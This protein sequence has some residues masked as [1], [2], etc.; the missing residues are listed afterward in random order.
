MHVFLL[1]NFCAKLYILPS[2]KAAAFKRPASRVPCTESPAYQVLPSVLFFFLGF[3][4]RQEI[5]TVVYSQTMDLSFLPSASEQRTGARFTVRSANSPSYTP[6]HGRGGRNLLSPHEARDEVRH[7]THGATN[8]ANKEEHALLG[9]HE[10]RSSVRG[11]CET[12]EDSDRFSKLYQN[13][14]AEFDRSENPAFEGAGRREGRKYSSQSRS[15]SLDRRD[16]LRATDSSTRVDTTVMS[17][18]EEKLPRELEKEQT[19]VENVRRAYKGHSFPSRKRSQSEHSI[20]IENSFW[21][22]GQSIMERIEKLYGSAGYDKAKEESRIKGVPTTTDLAQQKLYKWADGG[23]FPR[24][25]SSGVG[26]GLGSEKTPQKDKYFDSSVTAVGYRR[27]SGGQWQEQMQGRY[28]EEGGGSWM[29]GSGTRSLDRARSRN[30]L[31]AQ[32]RSA[33]AAAEVKEEPESKGPKEESQSKGP[34]EESQSKGPKEESQSKGPKE[35]PTVFKDLFHLRERNTSG[36]KDQSR[37]NHKEERNEP[38]SSNTD[39]DVFE[40][41]S[42]KVAERNKFSKALSP[43]SSTSVRNKI[44]QFEALSQ[45]VQGSVPRRAFSVPAQCSTRALGGLRDKWEGMKEAEVPGDNPEKKT[46]EAGAKFWTERALSVDEGRLRLRREEKQKDNLVGRKHTGLSSVDSLGEDVGKYSKLKN[47]LQLPVGEGSRRCR[48]DLHGNRTDPPKTSSPRHVTDG[49]MA[50]PMEKPAASQ[51]TSPASDDDKTPTNT[52]STSPCLSPAT[53]ENTPP[54][55]KTSG[56]ASVQPPDA[57]SPLVP[58]PLATSSHSSLPGLMSADVKKLF[59]TKKKGFRDLDAWVAGINSD[60]VWNDEDDNNEDDD[61]ESTQKD[62]DSN[63]D[64]DSGESSVTVTSNMSQS[65]RRSFCVSLSELCNFAGV[66]DDCENDPDDWQCSGRRSVSLCSDVSALSC[67]S[68]MPSEELDRLLED[69]RS[70]G[71]NTLQDY[72]DVQVVVLHKDMGAGLGF[73]LAGG[74]DQNKPVTVHKVFH[75]GVAAQEGSIKEGDHV[76]SI[77]GTA[78]CGY[79]HLEALRVLRKA[80]A[81]EMAVVVLRRG[82]ISGCC[83]GKVQG[84]KQGEAQAPFIETGQHVCVCLEKNNRDLGFTLEGGVGS[85][86]GDR[87]LVVQ[88]IFQGGPVDKVCPGDEVLDIEGVS[89]VGMS[90]LEAWTLIRKLAPG[91]VNVVLHRPLK[92]L[93]A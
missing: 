91:P 32:L 58:R 78:L 77:N 71:D 69:V 45:R 33:R 1:L 61:D 84:V 38:K 73:S 25:F 9:S 3:G 5:I 54:A 22:K 23:T 68:V 80:K 15:M 86:L 17:A 7:V 39:E 67:V 6:S 30:T 19:G 28:A 11:R 4:T 12:K 52:P 16:G 88:K 50:R 60:S 10:R 49:A 55:A 81:R 31:A 21:P 74:V 14:T 41:Y 76:L 85:S 36:S 87:P 83:K 24:R 75:S 13:G 27:F 44:N 26:N 62:E 64:S 43:P 35:E 63:Y 8:G 59:P 89:T 56:S 53:P 51:V 93:E 48:E 92:R 47:S 65:D 20:V 40:S 79:A 82:D 57:G 42:G 46:E 34:K 70:L 66:E 18:K 37:S 72:N 29:K 2:F 90:R